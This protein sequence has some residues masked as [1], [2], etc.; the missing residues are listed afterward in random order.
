VPNDKWLDRE[1]EEW[2]IGADTSLRFGGIGPMIWRYFHFFRWL[3]LRYLTQ[4]RLLAA[5]NIASVALGVAVYL[6][7]QIANHSANRAFAASVDVVA[8][9]T[10]LQVTAPTTGLADEIFPL[11]ARQP[12]IAAATPLVRGPVTLPDFP[13]EYLDLL[14]IDIFSNEP[15][16]T[17]DVTDL[18]AVAAPLSSP[19]RSSAKEGRG[20]TTDAAT[21]RRGY[22]FD[23]ERWL[24]RSD[25][26]AVSD[27][28]ARRHRLRKGDSVRVQL[29]GVTRAL[30]V[31][32][33]LRTRDA[34][35]PSQFAAMDIG[36]AQ[37]F[38][39]RRGK[40][41]AVQLR[42]TNPG[43]KE[44]MIAQLKALLPA[45]AMVR[46]PLQRSEQVEKMLSSFQLNL[47]AMSLVSL[48]VGVFLIYNTVAASVTRRRHEIGILRSLGVT[49]AEVRALF[50]SEALLLGILGSAL[51]ILAG[52]LLA[53]TLVGTVSET[54]SS[55]YVLIQVRQIS[56]A[57]WMFA[58]A[59]GIGALSVVVGAWLPA[60]QAARMEPVRALTSGAVSEQSV[61]LSH[62]WFWSGTICLLVSI[63]FGW[64]ALAAGPPWLGFI[65]AFLVLA[66]FAL[67]APIIATAFSRFFRRIGHIEV[68]L[69]ATNLSRALGKNSVTIAALACAVAMTVSISVMVFS[70]R[71]TVKV[72]IDETLVADLFIAP[73]ANE[74]VGPSSFMPPEA[75]PFLEQLPG[76]EAVD[77]FRG[78]ELP[79]RGGTI[80]VAVVRG[81]ERRSFHFL[82]GDGQ[83]ILR[84]FHTEQSV[85]VSES[86]AR[87]HRVRDGDTMQFPTPAGVQQF[88][89]VG[90]FYDYASDQG[91][92]FMSAKNFVNLWK[93]DRI[94]STAVY[95]NESGDAEAVSEAF[96]GKFGQAGEFAFYPNR[97]LRKRIFE[98]FDQ[99]FAVTYVLRSI[100][101]IVAV[102]GIFF[103]LTTLV[104]ERTREL[105]IL[106]AI[107][108]SA[109]Q[110]RR[111]LL[112]ESAMIGVLASALGLAAGISLSFVLT[113]VINRAFFGWTI[114]MTF[115]WMALA[116]T[117]AW[118][119]VSAV[120]AG[121]L[122]AFRAGKLPIADAVRSE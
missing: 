76:V 8:G 105:A 22:S 60:Q 25:S 97:D 71:Q 12:G 18:G 20:E 26:I 24:G 81:N 46:S 110:I 37:E 10:H 120:A 73:A 85:L 47:T 35:L 109:A 66:G 117:P 86:F 48:L 44:K 82:Q 68:N 92:V 103:T 90:V 32:F 21:E 99:T 13:G 89:I 104:T 36:W 80:G 67:F 15:Y 31:D 62:A 95:L 41:S 118:I 7:I 122:P 3:V 63:L 65:A 69:A 58:A 93:D 75:V 112:W 79:F 114:Q 61:R 56:T 64:L 101:V 38:L 6:A 4:H 19:R 33:I 83:A 96:R 9:K 45:D 77:T 121:W 98:I 53:R 30:R 57:P 28:F 88:N 40:L 115:P 119:V 94:N 59:F 42:L 106:R 78:V 87:R 27:E 23:I 108:A 11:V 43:D 29:H 14:G 100:A 17:F 91:V 52:L 50:F 55:L 70:F 111:L 102:V 16:R 5:L 84:R 116:L 39:Q 107:G 72:W 34:A 49:R 1:G 2:Q 74:I 54:I 51:G 113:S